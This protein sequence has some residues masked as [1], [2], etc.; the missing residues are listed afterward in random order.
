MNGLENDI[1]G[2]FN[3]MIEKQKKEAGAAVASTVLFNNESMVIHDQLPLDTASRMTEE[4]C[5]TCGFTAL[6]D[7]VDGTIHHIEHK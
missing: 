4:E 3:S 5:F 6:L 1:I 2:G 7:A